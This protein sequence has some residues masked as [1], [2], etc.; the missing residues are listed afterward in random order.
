MPSFALLA[1]LAVSRDHGECAG[2]CQTR[3]FRLLSDGESRPRFMGQRLYLLTS[4]RHCCTLA[5][6]RERGARKASAG[7][8]SE[9]TH[10]PIINKLLLIDFDD[11]GLIRK[12]SDLPMV[13][14]RGRVTPGSTLPANRS[15]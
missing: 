3:R 11:L 9:G 14:G 6:S 13:A 15:Q 7:E 8:I 10:F 2:R 4:A 12:P 5:A 1:N